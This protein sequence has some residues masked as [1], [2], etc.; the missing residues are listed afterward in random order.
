MK[1]KLDKWQSGSRHYAI[2]VVDVYYVFAQF[3]SLDQSQTSLHGK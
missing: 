1:C 2:V 3:T